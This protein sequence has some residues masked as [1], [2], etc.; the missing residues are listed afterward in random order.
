[1]W[2]KALGIQS[3]TNRR[4]CALHFPEDAF[5]LR[6]D[7]AAHVG[8]RRH[9][10]RDAIP[11]CCTT[12]PALGADHGPQDSQDNAATWSAAPALAAGHGP[13]DSQDN[14]AVSILEGS[15]YIAG[16]R[17]S[18]SVD[19]MPA[20]LSYWLPVTSLRDSPL[21]LYCLYTIGCPTCSWFFPIGCP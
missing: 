19:R 11:M 2:M 3:G 1:M 9:L 18:I 16:C 17:P 6:R 12:A 13:Q 4:V 5:Q 10:R 14:A 7:A 20:V 8:I 15:V 21:Y